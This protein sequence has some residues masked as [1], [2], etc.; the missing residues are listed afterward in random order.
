MQFE[1]KK[2]K[3]VIP[4]P[5]EEAPLILPEPSQHVNANI[6]E[7]LNHFKSDRLITVEKDVSTRKRSDEEKK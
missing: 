2:E 5:E 3:V 7:F 4:V 6:V 1:E